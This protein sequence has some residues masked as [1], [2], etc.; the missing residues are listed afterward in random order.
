M[1]EIYTEPRAIDDIK[2][3]TDDYLRRYS[4]EVHPDVLHIVGQ[5]M[6]IRDIAPM[7]EPTK[8]N[9]LT[10]YCTRD[11]ERILMQLQVDIIAEVEATYRDYTVGVGPSSHLEKTYFYRYESDGNGGGEVVAYIKWRADLSGLTVRQLGDIFYKAWNRA[12][13]SMSTR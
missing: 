6:G 5:F 11:A 2:D 3:A 1:K 7:Y 4:R 13:R 8:P 10:L 9:E 12:F